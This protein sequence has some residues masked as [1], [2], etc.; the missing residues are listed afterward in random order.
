MAQRPPYPL[1]SNMGTSR[2]ALAE[3]AV[4]NH[5]RHKGHQIVGTNVHSRF[6][7]IDILSQYCGILI[8]TEVKARGSN[9]F[10]TPAEFVNYRKQ[11]KIILC[12]KHFLNQHPVWHTVPIR[13]DV[14]C[15]TYHNDAM[16]IDIIEAAF[17]A[18]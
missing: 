18:N 6:G 13:F 3:Q 10:G 1:F 8:V 16:E 5:L 12:L 15:V 4:T 14:A 7:E 17:D 9:H 11:Q 2:G